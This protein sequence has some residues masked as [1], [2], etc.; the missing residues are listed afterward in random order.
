M[1]EDLHGWYWR[2]DD[3]PGQRLDPAAAHPPHD[4][5]LFRRRG[6]AGGDPAGGLQDRRTYD[7]NGWDISP[8]GV[9]RKPAWCGDTFPGA[10]GEVGRHRIGDVSRIRCGL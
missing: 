1:G 10:G 7:V 5:G 8:R 4:P 6:T 2:D 3:G 9:R